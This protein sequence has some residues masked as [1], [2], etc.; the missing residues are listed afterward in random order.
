MKYFVADTSSEMGIRQLGEEKVTLLANGALQY[1]H[2]QTGELRTVDSELWAT[3][4]DKTAMGAYNQL[5]DA[6]AKVESQLE[7]LK[8][9]REELVQSSPRLQRI[10]KQLKLF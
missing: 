1:R 9:T 4:W 2:P 6:I 10:A 8:C 3:D 7:R 5:N